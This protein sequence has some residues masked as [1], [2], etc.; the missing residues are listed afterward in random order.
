[1]PNARRAPKRALVPAS[2]E[3]IEHRIATYRPKGVVT[4]EEWVLVRERVRD[5]TRRYDPESLSAVYLTMRAATAFELWALNQRIDPDLE[6]LYTEENVSRFTATGMGHLSEH[7]RASYRSALR[8]IGRTVTKKALWAPDSARLRRKTMT[9]PYVWTDVIW[10]WDV[11]RQQK[12]EVRRR[13][14][15]T[16]TAL[17][18]GAGLQG[19]EYSTLHGS[20]IELVDGVAVVHVPGALARDV[21]VLPVFTDELMV[22]AARYPDRS[23]FSDRTPSRGWT[24]AV[25]AAVE[26]PSG[27][28]KLMPRRMRITWMVHLL[29]M[30]VRISE[31]KEL[32]GVSRLSGWEDLA[33]FI[34]R[35]NDTELRHLIGGAL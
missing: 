20:Q 4:A 2:R 9:N 30:G 5:A 19:P 22:L 27:A 25:L 12:S 3:L 33:E 29:T 8:R 17:A 35:R 18:A 7:S 31:L 28:P 1:M 32:A 16:A 10:L 23:M 34:P 14:A 21:P 11:A 6:V 26:I 15:V 24:A 13:A